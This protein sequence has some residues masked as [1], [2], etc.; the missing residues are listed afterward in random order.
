MIGAGKFSLESRCVLW[1]E[2]LDLNRQHTIPKK[3]RPGTSTTH[4]NEFLITLWSPVGHKIN[5]FNRRPGV[6]NRLIKETRIHWLADQTSPAGRSSHVIILDHFFLLIVSFKGNR[7]KKE[8]DDDHRPQD[9]KCPPVRVLAR[10]AARFSFFN[11]RP[12]IACRLLP[13]IEREG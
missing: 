1:H 12:L 6:P 8:N 3:K 9:V 2:V 5:A 10:A 4:R 13:V 7:R 11:N